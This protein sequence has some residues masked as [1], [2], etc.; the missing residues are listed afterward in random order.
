MTLPA[1]TECGDLPPGIHPATLADVAE[2]FGSA[3]AQRRRVFLRLER[4]YVLARATGHVAR[5]VVFGSFVTAKPEPN[6]VDV[7]FLMADSF[8]VS[9][10]SGEAHLLFDHLAAQAYF[11]ASVFWLR[12]MAVFD[13][14]KPRYNTGRSRG[15]GDAEASL[16]SFRRRHDRER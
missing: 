7:F 9:T 2:R 15:T 5:T 16:S 12:R 14:E 3:T 13:G 10:I 6:D 4:L 1:F 11:G 8:D